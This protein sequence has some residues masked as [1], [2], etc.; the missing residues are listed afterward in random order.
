MEQSKTGSRVLCYLGLVSWHRT[1][2]RPTV[3]MLLPVIDWGT[4][5]GSEPDGSMELEGFLMHVES[6]G[7][8]VSTGRCR[9][10]STQVACRVRYMSMMQ[11]QTR[12]GD[13]G[14][15]MQGQSPG[16]HLFEVWFYTVDRVPCH[17]HTRNVS[18][19]AY[20]VR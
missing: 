14:D 11:M 5:I 3:Y 4:P 17:T 2:G 9:A 7:A 18:V 1:A 8:T 19:F 6:V 15:C 16:E 12:P 10:T 13:C 20:R